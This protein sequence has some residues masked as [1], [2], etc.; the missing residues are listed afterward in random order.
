MH[1]HLAACAV[2]SKLLEFLLT[3]T[4]VIICSLLLLIQLDREL[5]TAIFSI[6]FKSVQEN[7]YHNSCYSYYLQ[8]EWCRR[9]V[10]KYKTVAKSG[11]KNHS[12]LTKAIRR[13]HMDASV[14]IQIVFSYTC[15]SIGSTHH[16]LSHYLMLS[17]FYLTALV[18][19]SF[20]TELT[21]MNCLLWYIRVWSSFDPDVTWIAT[22]KAHIKSSC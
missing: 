12:G 13:L 9:S 21:L 20:G 22:A 1:C 6:C 8:E 11:P 3:W 14:D 7:F 17:M 16:L 5:T 15:T 19:I 2:G 18:Q 10:V 4:A